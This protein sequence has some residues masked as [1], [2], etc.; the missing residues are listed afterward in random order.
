MV[1]NVELILNQNHT[2]M[3]LQQQ[4]KSVKSSSDKYI[5]K[6]NSE[7]ITARLTGKE[8]VLG[9]IIDTLRTNRHFVSSS[10]EFFNT[11]IKDYWSGE[12]TK[13]NVITTITKSIRMPFFRLKMFE[14]SDMQ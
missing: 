3:A 10:H 1:G 11:L 6:G 7:H 9:L 8:H 5:K 12:S 13:D 14:F 2:A 4:L